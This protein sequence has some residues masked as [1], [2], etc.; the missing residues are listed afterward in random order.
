MMFETDLEEM[1]MQ[2]MMELTV[3]VTVRRSRQ[4]ISRRD[5]V[6]L[7][8]NHG[9]TEIVAAWQMDRQDAWFVTF[10]N[11]AQVSELEGKNVI[12][13]ELLLHFDVCDRIVVKLKVHWLPL[14][15][16]Y[17]DVKRILAKYGEVKR[18]EHV[19]ENGIITGVRQ[20]ELSLREGEQRD[21]PYLSHI[22]G[23][24]CLI[25]IPGRLRVCFKCEEVEHLRGQNTSFKYGRPPTRSYA[26]VTQT[27]EAVGKPQE[28]VLDNK[29]VSKPVTEEE[30]VGI[31]C[32]C[33]IYND[34]VFCLSYID[35]YLNS[36]RKFRLS[37]F[38]CFQSVGILLA[39]FA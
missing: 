3:N 22:Y 26:S 25:V 7:L 12:Y 37:I 1:E 20:V 16:S 13:K 39:L 27:K 5:L 32:K 24:K 2:E 34:Y 10:S 15:V 30:V 9:Y 17:E 6:H 23:H 33:E 31:C 8:Q 14:W 29:A 36:S 4:G 28:H 19:T 21:I 11:N 18:V 38:V 35:L